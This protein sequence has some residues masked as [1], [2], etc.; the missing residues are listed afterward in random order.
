ML[1][2]SQDPFYHP[3]RW[4]DVW[5][6][7]LQVGRRVPPLPRA[8]R[9]PAK[10]APLAHAK[11]RTRHP[12]VSRIAT[13]R[14][15]TWRPQ[16]RPHGSSFRLLVLTLHQ[17]LRNRAATRAQHEPRT[18]VMLLARLAERASAPRGREAVVEH[19]HALHV[20]ALR[21]ITNHL[22]RRWREGAVAVEEL[23][24]A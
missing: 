7:G 5:W 6:S 8:R 2:A 9:L 23:P 18:L 20:E 17:A 24:R 14:P 11:H 3:Q 1:L 22:V 16:T 10:R 4:G 12:I 19:E 21:H 13:R 15:Q